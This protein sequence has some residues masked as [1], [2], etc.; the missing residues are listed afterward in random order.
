[1]I[2]TDPHET[3]IKI[4]LSVIIRKLKVFVFFVFVFVFFFFSNCRMFIISL[5]VVIS[6]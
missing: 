2:L 5:E 6:N 4:T 1:M 3:G